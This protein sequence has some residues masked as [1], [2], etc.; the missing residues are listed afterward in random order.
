MFQ[1]TPL[2]QCSRIADISCAIHLN[3][4]VS[5]ACGCIF[6]KPIQL[7]ETVVEYSTMCEHTL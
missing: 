4:V 6:P 1:K 5:A 7:Y 2:M 3:G